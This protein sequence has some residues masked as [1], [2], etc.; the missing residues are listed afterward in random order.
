MTTRTRRTTP[1]EAAPLK[2][3]QRH[4]WLTLRCHYMGNNRKVDLKKLVK[5]AAPHGRTSESE[6]TLDEKVFRAV[7]YLLNPKVL[8]PVRYQVNRAKSL[9]R[10]R[11]IAASHI[12]GERTYMIPSDKASEID[13]QLLGIAADVYV[14]AAELASRYDA[15]I[16]EQRIAAGPMFDR[17]KYPTKEEVKQAFSLDWDYV[18]FDSPDEL[19]T[20]D[21]AMA[22][23]SNARYEARLS[24]MFDET[25]RIMREEALEVVG[26]LEHK[27]EPDKN[28]DKKALH[29]SALKELQTYLENLPSR[30][31]GNDTR[32][33]DAMARITAI[34][35]GL[36]VKDIRSSDALRQQIKEAA[37]A[38]KAALGTLVESAPKR[39]I[40]FGAIGG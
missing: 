6:V 27:L 1:A 18:R 31:M 14:A 12:F 7:I 23:R 19:E 15:A 3:L 22:R 10:S 39:R 8:A 16:E 26:D 32:L 4:I 5:A 30:N 34:S 25:I 2:V 24:S 36:T 17:S 37:A 21:S 33:V 11:A 35:K 29:P 9:L 40:A 38:T 20:I 13:Q 28:G